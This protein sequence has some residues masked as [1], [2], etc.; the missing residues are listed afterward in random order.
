M[1]ALIVV[2]V[3]VVLLVLLGLAMHARQPHAQYASLNPHRK[4]TA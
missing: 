4:A 1:L 2:L 3:V